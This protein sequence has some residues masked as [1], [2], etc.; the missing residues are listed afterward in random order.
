MSVRVGSA[1]VHHHKDRWKKRGCGRIYARLQYAH[2]L[3]NNDER[4]PEGLEEDNLL[5]PRSLVDVC[6]S[7]II[8]DPTSQIIRL[9]RFTTQKHFD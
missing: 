5:S 3:L 8:V 4:D 9:V 6:V 2:R 1:T 7:F